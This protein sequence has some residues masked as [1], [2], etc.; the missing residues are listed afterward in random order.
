[1]RGTLRG[2][3]KNN[4]RATKE[5]VVLH[6]LVP[7]A[8]GEI[9][10]AD[11]QVLELTQA[12]KRRGPFKPVVLITQN[13]DY[14]S[15]LET[16]GIDV[17]RGYKINSFIRRVR[18][19]GRL[20]E[21]RNITLI[22][23]HGYDANY[24]TFLLRLFYPTTWG[25]KPTVVTCHGWIEFSLNY[26]IK[27]WLDFR[28]YIMSDALI[29]DSQKQ[30][31]RLKKYRNRQIVVC[32]HNGVSFRYKITNSASGASVKRKFGI[33]P[34]KK[35]I[36]AIGRLSYEKRIDI[37]LMACREIIK[38]RNDVCFLIIGSGPEE[39]RLKKYAESLGISD[40]V[41]FTGLITDMNP[42]YNEITMMILASDT[43]ATPRAVIEAMAH[44]LPV[45]ATNVG[46]LEEMI[47]HGVNGY[48]VRPGDYESMARYAMDLLDDSAELTEFGK[49]SQRIFKKKFTISVMQIKVEDVYRKVLRLGRNTKRIV[50]G[51]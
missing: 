47:I 34:E 9:G 14:A 30:L 32:V 1:M 13:Q 7:E 3:Q 51:I 40:R 27:T 33:P 20:R 38:K 2:M 24:L 26:K 16:S 18:F 28:T 6:V 46:D 10:G 39:K 8:A 15:R 17:V 35:L 41:I 45:I 49:E 5:Y 25:R 44:G 11:T 48:L 19:L 50:A 43:E 12:Q 21:L 31:S 4:L 42:V 29:T 36:A 37:Y 22:H 23:S